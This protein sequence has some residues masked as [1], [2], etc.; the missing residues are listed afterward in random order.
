MKVGTSGL[1]RTGALGIAFAFASLLTLG[2]GDDSG[3]SSGTK[4]DCGGACPD[5]QVCNTATNKCEP[6]GGDVKPCDGKC[7]EE[8][9]CDEEKNEC[10]DKPS[11]ELTCPDGQKACGETCADLTKDPNHC[12][13]CDTVCSG[14][15]ECVDSSCKF[16]CANASETVCEDGCHDL[17]TDANNCNECGH[18]CDDGL[19]CNNGEC[20]KNCNTGESVCGEACVNLQFDNAN[21]GKCGTV[22]DTENGESCKDGGC[23]KSCP[24]GYEDCNGTCVD[25]YSAETCGTSC[26][27]YKAC[28]AE[29]SEVCSNGECKVVCKDNQVLC[30]GACVDTKSDKNNC[31]GCGEEFK[32]AEDEKCN[33]GVCSKDCGSLVDCN[34]NC[35]D[36]QSHPDYCGASETCEGFAVCGDG[37]SCQTGE[38]KCSDAGQTMCKVGDDKICT[39]PQTSTKY[40]GCSAESAGLDCSAV[41]G[42]TAGVCENGACKL[43]CDETHANCDEDL[44][45]GCES[46][47]TSTESCGA[48]GVV[49]QDENASSVQ[50]IAGACKYVCKENMDFCGD[51]CSDV[52][53]DNDNCGWCGNKCSDGAQCTNGFCMIP[54]DKCENGYITTTVGDQEIK[55]YCINTET[56]F[57]N[58]RDRINQGKTYPE[59]GSNLNN[60][61]IIV[62]DLSFGDEPS[63]IPVGTAS[64]PFN[65]G[66][67]LGNGHLIE[68]NLTTTGSNVGLFGVIKGSIINDV[69]LKVNLTAKGTNITHVGALAGVVDSSQ[70]NHCMEHDA[71]VKAPENLDTGYTEEV[72]GL[73]GQVTNKSNVNRSSV[74]NLKVPLNG[75]GESGGFIGTVN[76]GSVVDNCS[77]DVEVT[78]T[79]DRYTDAVSVGLG[80]INGATIKNSTAKG[81][82]NLS[83]VKATIRGIGG[84]VGV[85]HFDAVVENCFADVEINAPS[86]YGVGGLVGG[87]SNQANRTGIIKASWA[88]GNI[89]CN[90]QCGGLL[91]QGEGFN[92]SDS[93]ATGNVDASGNYAGG[94]VGAL[95]YA[96]NVTNSYATGN[97]TSK[98]SYVGG[99]IGNVNGGTVKNSYATGTVNG[100]AFVG[101]LVGNAT[102]VTIDNVYSTGD[103]TSSVNVA[104]CQGGAN[105]CTGGAFGQIEGGT[106]LSNAYAKGSVKGGGYVGGLIGRLSGSTVTNVAAFGSATCLTAGNVTGIRAGGLV[107]CAVDG[108]SVTNAVAT[109][110]VKGSSEVGA[111]IGGV[112]RSTNT[113]RNAYG[114]GTVTGTNPGGV[115]GYFVDQGTFRIQNSYYWEENKNIIAIGTPAEKGA[116]PFKYNDSKEAVTS[117]NEKRKLTDAL[118]EGWVS[119]TCT[120]T[121]GP[122]DTVSIPVPKTLGAEI[123]K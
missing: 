102:N 59:D 79:A 1:K 120:L 47:L 112:H 92:V 23:V 36:P 119:A 83:N 45:N 97:V 123:C 29:N 71:V 86:A 88:K 21:C 115:V 24:A 8:Q 91:G 113:L 39:D 77:A 46:D 118:D 6:A 101:G 122:N 117:A 16:V 84:I 54:K 28:K 89:I 98:L 35:I 10:V 37:L 44:S 22:C 3:A 111:V 41:A 104:A 31:G 109:G 13:D 4:K 96:G 43:T 116:Y 65:K 95:S 108:W 63:W 52:S 14:G 7:T 66:Y 99:L 32:C 51:K 68:A 93:H 20:T 18:K 82:I 11:G 17:K 27:N 105:T 33:A 25:L 30:D 2:C 38:C 50:C 34:G 61:Y 103:V 87:W 15:Q 48:C 69:N 19:V 106:K 49:C 81:T 107:G 75:G 42:I 12:G 78:M 100:A 58:M 56:K 72:G 121:T 60:A 90:N 53:K 57:R 62:D 70:I 80:W 85:T 94:L 76:G 64:N 110:N 74:Y 9:T 5:G 40:C 26:D 114:T 73:I 67:F 55:A